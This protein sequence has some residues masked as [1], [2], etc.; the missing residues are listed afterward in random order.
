M[1]PAKARAVAR[2]MLPLIQPRHTRVPVEAVLDA[3]DAVAADPS[4]VKAWTARTLQWA[5]AEAIKDPETL[6]GNI[7]DAA[8]NAMTATL[9]EIEG[10]SQHGLRDTCCELVLAAAERVRLTALGRVWPHENNARRAKASGDERGAE[11]EYRLAFNAACW[12]AVLEPSPQFRCRAL[13]EAMKLANACNAPL[14]ALRIAKLGLDAADE[15][16]DAVSDKDRAVM[17]N[18]VKTLEAQV[19]ERYPHLSECV[20][21]P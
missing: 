14:E 5:M 7:A 21:G 16:K 9:C 10:Q 2:L 17:A 18:V 15:A 13:W 4:A 3:A 1:T 12:A 20:I 11:A 6:E 8:C 19:R